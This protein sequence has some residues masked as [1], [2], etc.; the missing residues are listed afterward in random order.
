MC[1]FVRVCV[2]MC[3]WSSLCYSSMNF[4]ITWQKCLPSQDNVSRVRHRSIASR[5][6]S[7]FEVKVKNV[8]FTGLSLHSFLCLISYCRGICVLW[9]QI[10]YYYVFVEIPVFNANSVA[11]YQT[12][13]VAS[14]LG[15]H[16]LSVTVLG[17][18]D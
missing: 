17:F 18:P 4:E 9:T 8:V 16:C 3:V 5:S 7:H 11:S 13:S 15:L 1:V 10:C 14:D 6:R 12:H 2:C